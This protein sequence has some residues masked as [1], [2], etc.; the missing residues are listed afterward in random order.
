MFDSESGGTAKGSLK[1]RLRV[2][3]IL[4]R[5][6]R[7]NK[8]RLNFDNINARRIINI[9]R[10]YLFFYT[11]VKMTLSRNLNTKNTII[12]NGIDN[13]QNATFTRTS[14][15]KEVEL[16]V[17]KK[18]RRKKG[19]NFES[20]TSEESALEMIKSELNQKYNVSNENISPYLIQDYLAIKSQSLDLFDEEI[21]EETKEALIKDRIIAEEDLTLIRKTASEDK[22]IFLSNDLDYDLKLNDKSLEKLAKSLEKQ[23][24]EIEKL[25]KEINDFNIITERKVKFTNLGSLLSNMIGIG[26]GLLTLPFSNARSLAL[27]THLISNSL[28][29]INKDVKMDV[30]ETKRKNYKINVKDIITSEKA[31][32]TSD[33]LLENTLE[34]LDH[35]RYKIKI[36]E[37]KIPDVDQKLKEIEVIEKGL[38]KK[39]RELKKL[40][41]SFEKSKIK[42]LERTNKT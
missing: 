1:D 36:Y 5:I 24:K 38:I 42:V 21:Q 30:S 10:I 16:E 35:L 6:S 19:I 22:D 31:L 7:K 2:L 41:E 14:D 25:S 17:I 3:T 28:E 40:V 9:N 18:V 13:I 12:Y 34:K 4:M 29:N 33:F 26:V 27:G 8:L 11:P 32:K 39:K 20:L 15:S 37:Y 23:K